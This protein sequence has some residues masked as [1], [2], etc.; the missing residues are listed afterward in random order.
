[1][2]ITQFVVGATFAGLHLFVAYTIPV[3]T[4][5]TITK[6]VTTAASAVS[7]AAVSAS[8]DVAASA[9]S[10][11]FGDYLKKLAFRAAGE[12][13]LAENVIAQMPAVVQEAK[14]A[15]E[16][17]T[18][19]TGYRAEYRKI[20]CIDTTGQSFAIW[21]N[22][23]YLFPLTALFVRFFIKSY[24]KRTSHM[25]ARSTTHETLAKA[26]QDAAH[27]VGRE[28]DSLGRGIEDTMEN[29]T[30]KLKYVKD[31]DEKE[32]LKR[33]VLKDLS[34]YKSRASKMNGNHAWNSPEAR[35]AA[36]KEIEQEAEA[37]KRALEERI[38]QALADDI[39]KS[40]S[41]AQKSR[42]NGSA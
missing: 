42:A 10:I 16:H 21:L 30:T 37:A 22:L 15:L 6:T 9:A 8:A 20:S 17:L 29:L 25:T 3:F 38:K 14:R 36:R 39:A 27:G 19:E 35:E 40:K 5:Y 31:E 18:Q 34:Q 23:T 28:I 11:G 32:R 7:S 24:I 33:E 12:E 1:M 13:G 4:P 41:E 2:Q 26:T